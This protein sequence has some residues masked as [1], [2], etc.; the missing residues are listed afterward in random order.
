M[1][2]TSSNDR[3][4]TRGIYSR[5]VGM[6]E[7][8]GEL[9]PATEMSLL[10]RRDSGDSSAVHELAL[11]SV[12]FIIA[13]QKRRHPM[14]GDVLEDALNNALMRAVRAA[15]LFDRSSD[16][17][18]M[19]YVGRF[20]DGALTDSLVAHLD[21]V[22]AGRTAQYEASA[23]NKFR[24]QFCHATDDLPTDEQIGDALGYSADRIAFL[25]SL[26]SSRMETATFDESGIAS[27]SVERIADPGD[28]ALTQLERARQ[29]QTIQRAKYNMT[30]KQ[31]EAFELIVE[32]G[33][34]WVEARPLLGVTSDK[35]I[36]D[37]LEGAKAKVHKEIMARG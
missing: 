31:R 9:T 27:S 23:L 19:A 14:G 35:A 36:A 6:S 37:R 18:F 30:Y 17:R 28:D 8:L 33:M 7:G 21:V 16:N 1:Q 32:Q 20:I 3:S 26:L 22:G 25:D 11:H 2:N 15:E 5:F 24:Y 13:R 12:R 34:T 10:D 4:V 29:M